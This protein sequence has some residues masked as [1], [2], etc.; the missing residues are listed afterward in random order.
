V[1][2]THNTPRLARNPLHLCES[3]LAGDPVI[4]AVRS[5][6]AR[7]GSHSRLHRQPHVNEPFLA[8]CNQTLRPLA[9]KKAY[10]TL[11]ERP[12]GSTP[13]PEFTIDL[14][15]RAVDVMRTTVAE[16]YQNQMS[17]CSMEDTMR[18]APLTFAALA[19]LLAF[20][21]PRQPATS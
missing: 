21:I 4:G 6:S 14:D 20:D 5:T 12:P 2:K 13:C 19:A 17:R 16:T 10:R 8:S 9:V 18:V 1:R 11:G 7:Q 15:P 3:L